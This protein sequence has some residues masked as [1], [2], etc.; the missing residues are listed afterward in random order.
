MPDE[1][2]EQIM[3]AYPPERCRRILEA[4]VQHANEPAH[5]PP[6]GD[7]IMALDVTMLREMGPNDAKRPLYYP[8]SG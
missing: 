1:Q 7:V 4:F 3:A 8:K 6:I 2:L 5:R